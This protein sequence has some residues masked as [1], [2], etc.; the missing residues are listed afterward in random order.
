MQ[1]DFRA[2]PAMAIRD[3]GTNK[4][5]AALVAVLASVTAASTTHG[6]EVSFARGAVVAADLPDGDWDLVASCRR[7]ESVG[8][9]CDYSEGRNAWRSHEARLPALLIGFKN[10]SAEGI[11]EAIRRLTRLD[12]IACHK[13]MGKDRFIA[14]APRKTTL[15]ASTIEAVVHIPGVSHVELDTGLYASVG[16]NGCAFEPVASPLQAV[17]QACGVPCASQPDL[18]QAWWFQAIDGPTGFATASNDRSRIV[19]IIDDGIDIS[20]PYLQGR[21]WTHSDGSHGWDFILNGPISAASAQE[22]GTQVAGIVA[23][24]TA[25][26]GSLVQLMPLRVSPLASALVA[27]ALYFASD[28]G[29]DVINMSLF[30]SEHSPTV[31]TALEYAGSQN[32]L[33]VVAAGNSGLDL[34]I[35]P[36]WP[37]LDGLTLKN[38]VTVQGVGD[39]TFPA[40]SDHASGLSFLAAPARCICTTAKG[41][42][43]WS[44]IGDTS[45]AAPIVSGAAA[46][47]L[48]DQRF[49]NW[50]APPN[51]ASLLMTNSKIAEQSRSTDFDDLARQFRFNT[52][53]LKFMERV[54]EE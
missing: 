2:V 34:K 44:E 11:R 42:N 49:A 45:A 17:P 13:V 54:L 28:N 40:L 8:S 36:R 48:A 7:R 37:A 15:A 4:R 9:G 25:N 22:H 12:A 18:S 10:P 41:G 1:P 21:L 43:T 6:Q 16:S 26:P 46:L 53:N 5:H 3:R 33:V 19:A 38:V 23:Q 20:H 29:A 32:R 14:F 30:M 27:D 52:L 24:M 39:Q 51:L 35:Q 47:I 31:T 50:H